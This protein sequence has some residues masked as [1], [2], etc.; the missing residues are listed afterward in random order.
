MPSN[1]RHRARDSSSLLASFNTATI[2]GMDALRSVAARATAA[3]CRTGTGAVFGGELAQALDRVFAADLPQ[4]F[5]AA[6]RT[7]LDAGLSPATCKRICELRSFQFPDSGE[8]DGGGANFFV[9]AFRERQ[10]TGELAIGTRI[11]QARW[12]PHRGQGARGCVIRETV[13]KK[14]VK[15]LPQLFWPAGLADQFNRA[16]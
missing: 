15:Q 12:F 16:T 10:D 4:A 2:W 13:R 3:C 14:L 8:F 6:W 9:F 11:A 7:G 5:K 1:A